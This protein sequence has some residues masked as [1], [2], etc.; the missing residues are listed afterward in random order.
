MNKRFI[1]I[2]LLL[3]AGNVLVSAQKNYRVID[4]RAAET[5]NSEM[6]SITRLAKYLT[7][8]ITNDH[9][10]ARAI[11]TFITHHITYSDT[12][13]RN[14]WL[15]TIE[16]KRQQQSEQVL[17]NRRAVCEGFANLYKDLCTAAGL[18]AEIVTGV[19][20][21]ESGRVSD[22]GHAWNAVQ[23]NGQWYLT[24]PTWGSG[25]ADYWTGRFIQEH[26]DAYF[27]VPAD[28]MIQSH[29]PDDPIWQLL[30][31]PVTEQEFRS[32]NKEALLTRAAES[33]TQSFVYQDSIKQWFRQDSVE[34]MLS[35]S[36]RILAYNPQSSVALARLGNH[37]YNQA[38]TI[39]F[40]GEEQILEALDDSQ[41]RLDTVQLLQQFDHAEKLL[42]KGWYYY[43]RVDDEKLNSIIEGLAPEPVLSAEFNYL[44]GLMQVWQITQLYKT[45]TS[46]SKNMSDDFYKTLNTVAQGAQSY[47]NTAEAVY[48]NYTGEIY[49]DALQKVKLHEALLYNYVAKADGAIIELKETFSE[50]TLQALAARL[51]RGEAT[52]RKMLVLVN[53][54]LAENP[55]AV[56][57]NSFLEEMPLVMAG[58]ESDRGYIYQFTLRKKYK[59]EWENQAL[60]NQKTATEITNAYLK[61]NEYVNSGLQYLKNATKNETITVLTERLL[62]IKSNMYAYVGDI[63]MR[64]L[65]NAL[66]RIKTDSEFSAQRKNLL[67]VCADILQYYNQALELVGDNKSAA[68]YLLGAIDA[69]KSTRKQLVN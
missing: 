61:C 4:K 37:F 27:L 15:G 2:I 58:F 68:S 46:S 51:D 49:K 16:N 42:Q 10:K 18:P 17:K 6:I 12:T 39:F 13:V 53:E 65:A 22:Y 26:Q 43:N 3:L 35:A 21:Q 66:N 24:D 50:A 11:Y 67:D 40:R 48:K 20:K 60:V 14:G 54:V 25:Y 1:I 30:P 38:V 62:S 59:R 55:S 64:Y 41:R 5:P 44:R 47:F 9:E 69:V 36:T 7:G 29:L 56:L 33:A 57:A 34:Q 8:N 19:V 31:N 23:L 63:Q 32:L 52:Y 28:Q 45:L